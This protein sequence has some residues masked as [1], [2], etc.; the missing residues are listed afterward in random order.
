MI[1]SCIFLSFA[2]GSQ[3]FLKRNKYA[4]AEKYVNIAL[5][6]RRKNC[7]AKKMTRRQIAKS[8]NNKKSKG[9]GAN[10]KAKKITRWN[11]PFWVQLGSDVYIHM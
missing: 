2:F 7:K 9:L 10:R 4:E 3:P 5:K 1:L 8:C 6:F 11:C